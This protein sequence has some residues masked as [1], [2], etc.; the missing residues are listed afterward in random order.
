MAHSVFDVDVSTGVSADAPLASANKPAAPNAGMALP[1]RF[2]V[3]TRFACDMAR[4]PNWLSLPLKRAIPRPSGQ[5]HARVIA[6]IRKR[7]PILVLHNEASR[8]RRWGI[9]CFSLRGVN[10][11]SAAGVVLSVTV[12]KLSS[13]VQL[14]PG[15]PEAMAEAFSNTVTL[16]Q[17]RHGSFHCDRIHH[18]INNCSSHA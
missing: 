16:Q 15:A 7:L 2:H 6:H 11:T 18:L 13:D 1:L 5:F 3:D 12:L 10:L 9:G 14:S 17:L 4:P 8:K